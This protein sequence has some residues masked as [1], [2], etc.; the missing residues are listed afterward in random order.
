MR[1]DVRGREH[2]L[3]LEAN[4]LA[5]AAEWIEHYRRFWSDQL[6]SLERFVTTRETARSRASRP[7]N[8]P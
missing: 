5:E 1:R 3:S 6:A 4:P 8:S 7:T 2:F